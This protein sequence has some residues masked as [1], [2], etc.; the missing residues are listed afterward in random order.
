MVCPSDQLNP[1]EFQFKVSSSEVVASDRAKDELPVWNVRLFNAVCENA[2]V[3]L[4]CRP[5]PLLTRI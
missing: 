4:I 5:P 1:A 2:P 3:M